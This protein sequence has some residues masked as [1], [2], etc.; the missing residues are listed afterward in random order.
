MD[1]ICSASAFSV[2]LNNGGSAHRRRSDPFTNSTTPPGDII[3]RD[4]CND[5][6][7]IGLRRDRGDRRVGVCIIIRV[8]TA[9]ADK[10]IICN[11]MERQLRIVDHHI[12]S[13][14]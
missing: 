11:A 6:G 7:G 12:L 9:E 4:G 3:S 1:N 13:Q 14:M 2:E 5:V 8:A 10:D